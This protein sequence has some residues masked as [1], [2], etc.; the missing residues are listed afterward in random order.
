MNS[1]ERANLLTSTDHD[2]ES[3]V[4]G[5][6]TVVLWVIAVSTAIVIASLFGLP[7]GLLRIPAGL[8][9]AFFAPGYAVLWLSGF[10]RVPGGMNHVV[11][12]MP[13][14]LAISVLVGVVLNVSPLGV[15]L[16][17]M[18]PTLA[19]LT[20]ILLAAALYRSQIGTPTGQ[21]AAPQEAPRSLA[22]HAVPSRPVTPMPAQASPGSRGRMS[23]WVVVAIALLLGASAAAAV[24]TGYG[25]VTAS[26]DIPMPFTEFYLGN[27]PDFPQEAGRRSDV[28]LALGVNNQETRVMTYTVQVFIEPWAGGTLAAGEQ[29]IRVEAGETWMGTFPVLVACGDSLAAQLLVPGQSAAYRSVRVR[30]NCDPPLLTPTP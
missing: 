6:H 1:E 10:S 18:G 15:R 26:Q 11:F 4:S 13:A 14:S 27:T 17:S 30:S 9:V 29:T 23:S 5:V 21:G 25:I 20:L 12:S 7:V 2:L 22:S 19:V 24:W 3:P 16:A 8:V 28:T